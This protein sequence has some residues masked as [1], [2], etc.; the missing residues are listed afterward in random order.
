MEWSTRLPVPEDVERLLG[1]SQ[2][3]KPRTFLS[4]HR[5]GATTGAGTPTSQPSKRFCID[6]DSHA[7]EAARPPGTPGFVR[8]TRSTLD[9]LRPSAAGNRRNRPAGAPS[10]CRRRH[11]PALS[12]PRKQPLNSAM[13][14][15]F[16]DGLPAR[17]VRRNTPSLP[18]ELKHA[19]RRPAH[20]K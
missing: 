8:G 1:K 15:V 18:E 11:G 17:T 10:P 7:G 4:A 2:G 3:I 9:G 5:R 12:N 16:V 14:P 19:R 20:G 13:A 6:Y